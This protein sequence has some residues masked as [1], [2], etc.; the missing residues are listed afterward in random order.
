M[1]REVRK[2][3]IDWNIE[4]IG[5]DV[6]HIHLHMII[7]PRSAVSDVVGDLKSVTSAKIKRNFSV[8]LSKVY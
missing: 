7:P 8:F 3:H 1:I 2:F 6:D 4:K 5:I